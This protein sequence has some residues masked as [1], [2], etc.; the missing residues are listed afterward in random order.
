M[1]KSLLLSLFLAGLSVSAVAETK[2]DVI[3]A[4][5]PSQNKVVS[6]VAGSAGGAGV[7][8]AAIGQ[9]LGLTVVT[10]SSG[11]L[12]LSGSGGYIAGTLGAAVAAPTIIAVAVVVGGTAATVELVCAPR[13]HPEYVAKVE[14]AAIEAKRR[15]GESISAATGSSSQKIERISAKFS[16]VKANVFEYIYR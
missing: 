6:G 15:W 1:K 14:A 10:H 5:A 4:Y 16:D 8:T 2:G 12:I 13:N 7:A 9:L 11:A 3:C